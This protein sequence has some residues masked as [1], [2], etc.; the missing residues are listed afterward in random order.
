MVLISGVGLLLL[1]MT[2]RLGRVVDRSRQLESREPESPD[3]RRSQRIQIRILWR[4]ARLLT[5]SIALASGCILCVALLILTLFAGSVLGVPLTGLVEAFFLLGLLLV[6][7]SLALFIKDVTLT[8]KALQLE[9]R[10]HVD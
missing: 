3:E 8:L 6:I 2:N 7:G 4:R 5:V 9:I 1:S 10:R